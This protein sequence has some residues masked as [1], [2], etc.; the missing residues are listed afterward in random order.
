[1]P[2]LIK[3]PEYGWVRMPSGMLPDMLLKIYPLIQSEMQ[4]QSPG[5]DR[6]I[7]EKHQGMWIGSGNQR[8]KYLVFQMTTLAL[9]A[10][11]HGILFPKAAIAESEI[12]LAP[13]RAILHFPSDQSH[14]SG[15]LV[16]AM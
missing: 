16:I 13:L 1:M 2:K 10:Q 15:D 4:I 6:H 8:Q 5:A 14:E 7:T 3:M 9:I 11:M 12:L